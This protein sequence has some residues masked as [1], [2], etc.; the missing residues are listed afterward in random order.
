MLA[1]M[2]GLDPAGHTGSAANPPFCRVT[3]KLAPSSDS[4][5]TVELWLP[6]SGWNG[7]FAAAASYLC[8]QP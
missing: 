1:G 4:D 2:P 7:K 6:A 8:A 3:V 5:V